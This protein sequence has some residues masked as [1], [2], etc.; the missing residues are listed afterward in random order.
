MVVQPATASLRP[1]ENDWKAFTVAGN[2]K[3]PK[4]AGGCPS[5]TNMEWVNNPRIWFKINESMT[6]HVLL[7]I[8]NE[9][10][11][12]IGFVVC[13][14]DEQKNR[15]TRL[16]VSPFRTDQE[17]TMCLGTLKPGCYLIL[18]CTYQPKLEGTFEIAT[19]STGSITLINL[20]K[21]LR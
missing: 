14:S 3:Q 12:G 19:Y 21:D 20:D 9:A 13:E 8:K 10:I 18:P 4:H 11:R 1:I 6:A 16:H 15:G 7:V 17:V 2:W 5:G